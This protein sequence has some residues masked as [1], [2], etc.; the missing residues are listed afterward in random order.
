MF[1]N[2]LRYRNGL[3]LWWSLTLVGV[4]VGIF[5]TQTGGGE[6]ANGGTWQGYLLG[7][8]GALLIV[9]LTLLGVRK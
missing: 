4:C 9:W 5:A 2:I 6:P 1:T 7:T 3:H 8:I